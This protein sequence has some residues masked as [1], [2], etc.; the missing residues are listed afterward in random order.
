MPE[1]LFAIAKASRVE[2]GRILELG[3]LAGIGLCFPE[4]LAEV[5]ARFAGVDVPRPPHWGGFLLV[6]EYYEFW[7]HRQDRLH[8]RIVYRLDEALW[9]RERLSP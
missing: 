1:D 6:P 8:D 9:R 7:Q 5:E 3:H 4:V 2:A